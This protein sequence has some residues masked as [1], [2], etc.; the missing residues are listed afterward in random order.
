MNHTKA[1]TQTSNIFDIRCNANAI[2]TSQALNNISE[3]NKQLYV[4]SS[5]HINLAGITKHYPPA[6]KEWFNSIYA[7]NKN[8]VRLLPSIDKTIS[9]LIKGHFNSY[10]RV[11]EKRVK[12]ARS[13]RYRVRKVRLSTNR[14]LVSRAE[15]KHT[16]DKVIITVYVYNNEKKYFYNKV[17]HMST[18]DQA[19]RLLKG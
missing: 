6:N 13:R 5:R 15:I 16:N 19:G 18:I 9:K 3:N 14:I 4:S 10:S 17:K 7:Y 1:L 12:K 2:N 8:Y 11:L